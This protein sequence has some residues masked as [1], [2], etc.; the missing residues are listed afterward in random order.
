MIKQKNITQAKLL[1]PIIAQYNENEK[2]NE[3]CS[4]DS[5]MSVKNII[6]H[7]PFSYME[8]NSN[9]MNKK[10]DISQSKLDYFRN[11]YN[12]NLYYS[13]NYFSK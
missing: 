8:K 13:D 3:S 6:R 7:T 12:P 9:Y 2:K 1:V 5:K 4:S 11:M 10:E